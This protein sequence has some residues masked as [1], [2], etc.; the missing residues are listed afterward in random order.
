MVEP[1]EIPDTAV[2]DWEFQKKPDKSSRRTTYGTRPHP[3]MSWGTVLVY[4][5]AAGFVGVAA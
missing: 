2:P 3:Q 5:A 1:T 4:G